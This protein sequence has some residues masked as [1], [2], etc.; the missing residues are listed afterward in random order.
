[1][2]SSLVKSLSSAAMLLAMSTALAAQAVDLGPQ[3]SQADGVAIQVTPMDIAPTAK[4]WKF[5]VALNTHSQSLGDDLATEASLVD[6]AGKAH[7]ATRW[8]GDP[9]GGHHRKGMLRFAPLSPTPV[10]I[11]M[12]IQRP[13]ESTARTFRWSAQ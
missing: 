7:P 10:Q 5:A 13:S 1:M 6:A 8:D 3:T 11:E 4:E 9:P 12:R 2:R